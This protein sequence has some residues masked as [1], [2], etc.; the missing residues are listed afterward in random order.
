[1]TFNETFACV[2]DSSE[3]DRVILWHEAISGRSAED[4]ASAYLKCI[5]LIMSHSGQINV[6]D[7]TKIGRCT[8]QCVSV[9]MLHGDPRR[10]H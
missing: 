9:S 1:M 7:K 2:N 3:S 8:L 4:V 6:P 10:K 5:E